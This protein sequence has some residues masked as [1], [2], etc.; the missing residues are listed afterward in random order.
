[1]ILPNE[2]LQGFWGG[3][4]K[5]FKRRMYF[6]FKYHKKE[7]GNFM[8]LL[9]QN[10]KIQLYLYT[11]LPLDVAELILRRCDVLQ[12]FPEPFRHSYSKSS[13]EVKHAV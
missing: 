5:L 9:S 6:Q 2:G 13:T 12:Y 3:I 11:A 4:G 7:I 10:S 8:Q 1:V